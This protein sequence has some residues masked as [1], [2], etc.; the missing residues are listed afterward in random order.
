M[1]FVVATPIHSVV[2]LS[3]YP[4][5]ALSC[6][7]CR[8]LESLKPSYTAPNHSGP[9]SCMP[10][11]CT[12]LIPRFTRVVVQVVDIPVS[13]SLQAPLSC[14]SNYDG[15]LSSL[16]T[17][18]C[19]NRS[20][21][22]SAR[23]DRSITVSCCLLRSNHSKRLLARSRSDCSLE[24]I[25]QSLFPSCCFLLGVMCRSM[26]IGCPLCYRCRSIPPVIYFRCWY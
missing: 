14:R 16:L 3:L 20:K 13:S 23:S 1:V 6:C 26:S 19:S 24:V 15:P 25:V 10:W 4:V 21:R 18:Q 2:A 11:Y 5:V 22:L 7:S 9:A 17:V 12:C 8:C